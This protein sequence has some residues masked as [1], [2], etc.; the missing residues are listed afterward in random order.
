MVR[1]CNRAWSY[2]A[3]TIVWDKNC[4]IALI[5]IAQYATVYVAIHPLSLKPE[6]P[7]WYGVRLGP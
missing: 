1:K 4:G 6:V 5:N 7:P 2:D 3:I